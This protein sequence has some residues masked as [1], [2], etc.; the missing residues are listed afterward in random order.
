MTLA[1]VFSIFV[2]PPILLGSFLATLLLW[3]HARRESRGN[4]ITVLM[5]EYRRPEMLDAIMTLHNL[6]K[7][8]CKEDEHI[9]C[10]YEK[11]KKRQDLEIENSSADKRGALI[12]QSLHNKRRLVTQFY[13]SLHACVK[14]KIVR[15]KDA[16][17][18]WPSGTIKGIWDI[19]E[20]IGYDPDK[21]IDILY[22]RALKYE[23]RIQRRL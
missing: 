20:P 9:K 14:N 1:E 22:K 3:Q 12:N 4:T 10:L 16:F 13:S 2:M 7:R 19:I 15:K 23:R 17:S 6:K 18:Y 8:S 11:I 21:E 5:M